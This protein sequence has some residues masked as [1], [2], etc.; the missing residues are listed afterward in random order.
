MVT[1]CFLDAL[2]ELFVHSLTLAS[3]IYH[4]Y[5]SFVLIFR[6]VNHNYYKSKAFEDFSTEG[7]AGS[8]AGFSINLCHLNSNNRSKI[9]PFQLS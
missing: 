6:L 3:D 7:L 4:L 2:K 8:K 5:R 1:F 9:L